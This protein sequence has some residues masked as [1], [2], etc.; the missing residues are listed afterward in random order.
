[1]TDYPRPQPSTPVRNISWYLPLTYTRNLL[2]IFQQIEMFHN[3]GTKDEETTH[4]D[5]KGSI[6]ADHPTA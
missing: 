6:A 2:F 5:P 1:M 3:Q 4:T